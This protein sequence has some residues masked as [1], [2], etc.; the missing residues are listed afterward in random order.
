MA[1]L[2]ALLPKTRQDDALD[3]AFWPAMAAFERAAEAIRKHTNDDRL[4]A[5]VLEAPKQ[6]TRALAMG[7]EARGTILYRHLERLRALARYPVTFEHYDVFC[8]ETGR[9]LPA[10]QNW[11]RGR[12]PVIL[13][14]WHDARAYCDWVSEQSGRPYGLPT[15]AQWE[16]ACRAGTQT[17]RYGPLDD[18]AWYGENSGGQTQPVGQKTPN[19]WGLHDMLGTVW[20]WCDDVQRVYTDATMRDP[21][22]P[23]DSPMRALRGG[24][25]NSGAPVRPGP[26]RRSGRRGV[27]SGGGI[28]RALGP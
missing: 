5:K 10:D 17:A 19:A 22:G 4:I 26:T 1:A 23:R 18:V 25:W 20:E 8:R 14:S 6:L 24:S 12:R 7:G 2:K 16:Y 13:V 9:D 21:A 15:E 11:G 28:G 27:A 3:A